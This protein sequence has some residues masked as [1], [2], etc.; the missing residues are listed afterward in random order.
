MLATYGEWVKLPPCWPSHEAL[1]TELC[2]LRHWHR[3]ALE[4]GSDPAECRHEPPLSY[5]ADAAQARRAALGQHL[6]LVRNHPLNG[7]IRRL[8]RGRIPTLPAIVPRLWV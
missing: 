6:E 1:S 2:V 7:R 8:H 5:E 3:T 4:L